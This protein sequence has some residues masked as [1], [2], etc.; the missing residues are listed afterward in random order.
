MMQIE[1]TPLQQERL[2]I[3]TLGRFLVKRDNKVISECWRTSKPWL[4]FK[5]FLTHRGKNILPES[6]LENLWPQ[7]QYTDPRRAFRSL[8]FRLRNLL[9]P[10]CSSFFDSYISFSHGCY[11]WNTELDYWFDAEEF[12]HL[13]QKAH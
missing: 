10:N 8:V 4:L 2:E 7:Q 1:K 9:S 12:E 13:C 11:H 5:Y 6:A 3:Y